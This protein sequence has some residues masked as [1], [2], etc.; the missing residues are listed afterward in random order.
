MRAEFCF[1]GFTEGEKLLSVPGCCFS[2][3]W[4][5]CFPHRK[6]LKERM[7]IHFSKVATFLHHNSSSSAHRILTYFP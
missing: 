4:E 2:T 3:E 5:K 1:Q 7:K 6:L